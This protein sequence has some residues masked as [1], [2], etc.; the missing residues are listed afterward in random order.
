MSKKIGNRIIGDVEMSEDRNRKKIITDLDSN[1]FVEAGAGAGKTTLIVSRII[2]Q[3]KDK[4]LPEEIV[5][6]TFTNAA[7]EELRSRIIQKVREAVNDVRFS[8]EERSKLSNALNHMDLMNISTIHSF[9]LKLLKERIFDAKLPMDVELLEETDGLKE[10]NKF[11]TEWSKKLKAEDWTALSQFDEDR[12]T[13]MFRVKEI[14]LQICELPD[15]T[16]FKYQKNVKD[17]KSEIKQILEEFEKELCVSWGKIIGNPS[18]KLKDLPNKD[19]NNTPKLGRTGSKFAE[20]MMWKRVHYADLLKKVYGGKEFFLPANK[21]FPI[22]KAE[23]EHCV[24]WWEQR[25]EK[26]EQLLEDAAN[27]KFGVILQYAIEAREAYRSE[28]GRSI[29]K[30]TNDDLLQKTHCLICNSK[31]AREYFASKIKCIYVDEFQ[32]T[33]HIQEEFIWR[34][35]AE[36]DAGTKL[37]DGR[38][39]LVG[40]PKQSIYRFRGAEPEVYFHAKEK[41]EALDNCAVYTL[42]YNFRSGKEVIDWVNTAFAARKTTS[43]G[44]YSPM[45]VQKQCLPNSGMNRLEGVYYYRE[46]E[47]PNVTYA[48]DAKALVKLIH[49]LVKMQYQIVDYKDG[50]PYER[51]ITY[52]DFLVLCRGKAKMSIYLKQ[53]QEEGI[54]VLL[55]GTLTLHEY[56]ALGNYVRIYDS[57]IHSFDYAKEVGALEAL[58]KS[59]FSNGKEVLT[60]LREA[61][62]QMSYYGVAE[63]LLNRIDVLLPKNQEISYLQLRSVKTKL[64]QMFENVLAESDISSEALS[65][66]FWNYLNQA[67]ERELPLEENSN[68]VRFMNLHKAKGLEGQIVILT[69]RDEDILPRPGAFRKGNEYY[70]AYGSWKSY[71][72]IKDSSSGQSYEDLAKAQES[73]ENTRLEY[74]A[75][76]R[77]KQALIFM[78]VIQKQGNSK[79]M[80]TGYPLKQNSKV[81]NIEAV[82]LKDLKESPENISAENYVYNEKIESAQAP[83]YVNSRPSTLERTS[84]IRQKAYKM[85]TD[86]ERESYLPKVRPI[87]NIIGNVMHRGLE[88]LI[89]RWSTDFESEPK[90]LK[91]LFKVCTNQ[92]ISENLKD[93]DEKQVENYR[94]FMIRVLSLFAEWAYQKKLFIKAKKVYTELKFSYFKDQMEF[95]GNCFPT[96]MNGTADLIVEQQDGSF[97]VLDYKSDYAPYLTA[98]KYESSLKEKYEGQLWEYRYAVSRLFNVEEKNVNLG[99]VSFEGEEKLTLRCTVI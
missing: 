65:E 56:L 45:I 85:L 38:L 36:D 44:T 95:D 94:T 28:A 91:N 17:P 74:V 77:A 82:I 13:I 51:A 71:K 35:A 24:Q 43:K 55:N 21:N 61:T 86:E 69:I 87:G 53:M 79:C 73:E 54:P 57:L 42:N 30:I 39:F 16:E 83:S 22:V 11:F 75:A 12:S 5:V 31:E 98:E 50:T 67:L 72:N 15:Y 34:L 46:P 32:D 58:E 1:V 64:Q 70:P 97:I 80:F 7:A 9:C 63:Y 25:K 49:N 90:K 8:E 88:L 37:R 84:K 76:T 6:I 89:N 3:L 4:F 33:D 18:V 96:W 52:G 81:G 66:K 48:E 27:Y 26:C 29:R 40:D 62:K 23:K 47:K 60:K 68:S 2:N 78:D 41:M 19:S 10:K 99:L 14:F 59:G 92:A 20:R 93:I